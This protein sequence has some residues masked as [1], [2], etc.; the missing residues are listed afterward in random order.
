[1]KKITFLLSLF[2]FSLFFFGNA[3]EIYVSDA[4][5]FNIGP[6]QILKYDQ[7]G[8]NPEV[9]IN[10]N[11][12][13]PQDI[14]FLESDNVV[15][16]SNLNTGLINRHNA[17]TGAYI[18]AFASGIAGPTR[19]KIGDDN[20]L[21]VL[22]WNGNGNVLRYQL[23]G[24]FVDEFTS[25]GVFRSIG[26]D[27]DDS[28]NLYVS[29]YNTSTIRKY[30][31]SG[32]DLG[33]FINTNLSGPTNIWF[34][35]NGDLYAN[36]WNN[37]TVSRFD[38]SGNFI[39]TWISDIGECEGVAFLP[40]GNILIGKGT[41]GEVKQYQPDG[42]FVE[43]TVTSGLGGLVRPNAVVLRG[44]SLSDADFESTET[45]F[46]V[47]SVGSKFKL[48]QKVDL[49]NNAFEVY[50]LNGKLVEKVKMDNDLIWNADSYSEGLYLIVATLEDGNRITQKV[51][52]KK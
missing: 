16:I 7:N 23:D 24:T 35:S 47:P 33:I 31:S 43:N 3:Q 37:G 21:Y 51:I 6:W 40:N 46:V 34:A 8:E 10:T 1:M 22:Q 44:F 14:V 5:S 50:N 48:S 38:S 45:V 11:L 49:Q 29:Y 26:L 19:M 13:W 15:L 28:G 39:E 4:A 27:W 18:D 12:G 52:V 41:T 32:N 2:T 25:A 42:T 20:L 9:F 30:D 36:N 17:T